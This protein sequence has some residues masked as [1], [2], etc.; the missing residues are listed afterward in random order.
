MM[1]D[2]TRYESHDEYEGDGLSVS[3]DMHQSDLFHSDGLSKS[4]PSAFS[5]V[6]MCA[7]SELNS[8][9][10]YNSYN[11]KEKRKK[12]SEV[13]NDRY[14]CE[15][16]G[17][18]FKFRYLLRRHMPVHIDGLRYRCKYCDKSYARKD[19]L[20][21]HLITHSGGVQQSEDRTFSFLG[22]KDS[23]PMQTPDVT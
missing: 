19:S 23:P 18:T 20:M 17:K 2:A 10:S 7:T 5:G 15:E 3:R 1:H 16:C 9:T 6:T 11:T 13:G 8:C 12:S 21:E 4:I 22:G 14:K